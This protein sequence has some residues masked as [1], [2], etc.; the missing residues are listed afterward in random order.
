LFGRQ[1]DLGGN[2][3]RGE[4]VGINLVLAQLVADSHLI[5]QA[6]GICFLSRFH[7]V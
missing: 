2:R 6:R 4:V 5:E 1:P 7:D 3:F